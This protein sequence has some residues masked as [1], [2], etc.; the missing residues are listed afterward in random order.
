MNPIITA[1]SLS[2]L[3]TTALARRLNVSRQYI[4][5]VEQGLYE[6]PSD[7][8]LTWAVNTINRNRP[9]DNQV[10]KKAIL[11]LYKE[12]QWQK[13]ESEKFDLMLRPLSVTEF[14]RMRQPDL[15]Y[16]YKIFNNW[17]RDYWPTAHAMAVSLCIHPD[18]ISRYED[19]ITVTMPKQIR[20]V[21]EELKLLDSSFKTGER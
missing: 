4:N 7:D 15:I 10:T 16:Y 14:D 20:Y 17:R 6:R 5:R 11:Q 21:L 9:E 1:R 2:L 13:R 18:P 12:W 19:G 3:S 8:I